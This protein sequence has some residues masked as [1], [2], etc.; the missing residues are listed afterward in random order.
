[1]ISYNFLEIKVFDLDTTGIDIWLLNLIEKE[2]FKLSSLNFIFCSD[3]YLLRVNNTYLEHDYYTDVITF[4]YN[5]SDFIIGDVYISV[6]RVADN[7][8]SYN[9]SFLNELLRVIVHGVLH[10]CG[11]KDKT[12]DE[13]LLMKSKEDFYLSVFV[14]RET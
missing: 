7:A 9:V 3:D 10:L 14:S 12:Q 2:G 6:D 1:M 13:S 11:Y 8:I 4:D 5:E